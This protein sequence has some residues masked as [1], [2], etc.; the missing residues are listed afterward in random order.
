MLE[1]ASEGKTVHS[2]QKPVEL[3]EYLIKTYSNEGDT[4]LDFTAG[5]F[6][7]GVACVNLNRKGI[8]IEKDPHYF[9]VGS[10]R[11]MRA[12]SEKGD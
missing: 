5:S 7:T 1:F 12:L 4:I 10:E 3:M 2:T 8:M 6:T 9:E 11:V